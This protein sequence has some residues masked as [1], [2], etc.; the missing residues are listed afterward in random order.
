LPHKRGNA[1]RLLLHQNAT[2]SRAS[3]TLSLAEIDQSRVAP[4]FSVTGSIQE[5]PARRQREV[6]ENQMK[7]IR[8]YADSM[9]SIPLDRNYANA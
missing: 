4:G 7:R 1:D 3:E 5:S 8:G 6:L 9:S 2:G